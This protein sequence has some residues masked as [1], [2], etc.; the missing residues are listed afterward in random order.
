MTTTIVQLG[1][2]S[3]QPAVVPQ[4]QST[5][6]RK[7]LGRRNGPPTRHSSLTY[8]SS[9]TSNQ[10][11]SNPR[12]SFDGCRGSAGSRFDMA[13]PS[14]RLQMTDV[15]S[16]FSWSTDEVG[17]GLAP[18]MRSQEARTRRSYRHMTRWNGYSTRFAPSRR[19]RRIS[20][21]R[22]CA[23]RRSVSGNLG[24]GLENGAVAETKVAVTTSA[25]GLT[26]SLRRRAAVHE[27]KRHELCR[28]GAPARTGG[29]WRA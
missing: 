3:A 20:A 15:T 11:P 17:A 4:N 19:H 25:A 1:F 12:A 21:R 26:G 13:A 22:P 6:S 2:V 27:A 16:A 23:R 8:F 7:K 18:T 14:R 24:R 28:R 5:Q 10:S 9:I 29:S